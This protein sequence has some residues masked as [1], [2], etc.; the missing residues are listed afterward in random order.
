MANDFGRSSRLGLEEAFHLLVGELRR[1][2]RLILQEL[3]CL[4]RCLRDWERLSHPPCT[5][6]IWHAISYRVSLFHSLSSF[7]FLFFILGFT[8]RLVLSIYLSLSL[9][10]Q[11]RRWSQ[12]DNTLLTKK[13]KKIDYL[14]RFTKYC[15]GWGEVGR[16]P[17]DPTVVSFG[18]WLF[19][20]TE[21]RCSVS[22]L[23]SLE[24]FIL[25][26]PKVVNYLR[27]EIFTIFLQQILSDRVLLI[28][29]I[30][31]KK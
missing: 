23:D 26:N 18:L 27:N 9:W 4:Q 15:L 20:L 8:L 24:Y 1:S 22:N 7:L 25:S 16:T 2:H 29:I 19:T 30:R 14:L 5:H 6:R 11:R 21:G 17:W 12:R 10:R 31:A 3:R 28:I 13:K